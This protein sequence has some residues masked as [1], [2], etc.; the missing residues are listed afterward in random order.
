M[1]HSIRIARK[2]GAHAPYA[3]RSV[4]PRPLELLSVEEAARYAKV[5]VQ[6][7]RRWLKSGKLRF[8]RAGRQIRIDVSDLVHSLSE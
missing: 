3:E 2:P 6:T 4:A 1:A 5:S 8:Y 7:V